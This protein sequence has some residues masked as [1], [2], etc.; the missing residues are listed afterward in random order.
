[1]LRSRVAAKIS[2]FPAQANRHVSP[3]R[4][5]SAFTSTRITRSIAKKSSLA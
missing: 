1:M 3:R 5:C 2:V 4:R